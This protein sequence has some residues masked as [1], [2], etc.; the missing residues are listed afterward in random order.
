M[1]DLN[2]SVVKC[3]MDSD[4][5]IDISNILRDFK[6]KLEMEPRVVLSAGFGDGKTYFLK[7]F[8]EK[9][10][11]SYHFF[12]IFPAQYVIGSNE[13]IFEYIKRDL[14]F[15]IVDQG[16]ITT[17]FDL[18]GMLKEM[19]EHVDIT[20]V[21]SFFMSRPVASALGNAIKGLKNLV[22]EGQDNTYSASKYL[23]SFLSVRGGLY[24]NDAYTCL[25]RK[26]FERL[27]ERDKKEIVLIVEDLDRIDPANIFSILNIFGSHFDRHYV[28]GKEEQ[29][30]KF[31][32]DRLITVMD[33]DNVESLYNSQYVEDGR[34]NFEGYISK[35]ICSKP[36]RYSIRSEAWRIVADKIYSMYGF[37]NQDDPGM[38]LLLS[39][40]LKKMSIR[41]LERV[42]LFDPM[43]MLRNPEDAVDI[44]GHKLSPSSPIVRMQAYRLFF[45]ISFS[46]ITSTEKTPDELTEVEAVGPLFILKEP[47]IEGEEPCEYLRYNDQMFHIKTHY[48]GNGWIERFSFKKTNSYVTPYITANL[49]DDG[50]G[51]ISSKLWSVESRFEPYFFYSPDPE[52]LDT[53]ETDSEEEEDGYLM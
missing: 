1:L 42:F 11:D 14:L 30:N 48:D 10:K 15:Q 43:R 51:F 19:M 41:E 3:H 7:R 38:K 44:N 20:E 13:A 8:Q 18:A 4:F 35:Y 37:N 25:I 5:V 23:D 29:E 21:L 45:D 26:C 53:V 24:E 52:D 34:G 36:F 39:Q 40:E 17:E 16:I 27:R 28:V 46:G 6:H 47:G 49:P 33:Y 2:E 9:Y 12:T 22:Q 31:G 32:V 50:Y